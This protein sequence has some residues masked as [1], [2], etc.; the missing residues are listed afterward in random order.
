MSARSE[1]AAREINKINLFFGLMPKLGLR[2]AKTRPFEGMT[3][4]VNA[5]LTTLTATLIRELAL[6]GG[7]WVVSASGSATTDRAVVDLLREQGIPVFSGGGAVDRHMEV[8]KHNPDLIADVGFDLIETLIERRPDLTDKVRGA[9]ELTRSGITKLRGLD[10]VP[11][12]VINIHDGELKPHV[13]NRH[14]VG[15]SLWLAVRD[16]TG[17]H[18]AGRRVLVVGY[19][20]VGEG[21]AAYARA[22][23]AIVQVVDESPVKRLA[24]HY[25][26]FG[27]PDMTEALRCAEIVVTATGVTGALK[28]K[29][30][31]KIERDI[32]LVNAGHGGD[33]IDIAGLKE[34][35]SEAVEVGKNCTRYRLGKGRWISVLG[36]GYPLNIVTNSGSPEPVLLH[37]ALLGLTLEWLAKNSI[38]NGEMQV[39]K[40]VEEEVAKLALEVLT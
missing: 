16:E 3:I 2:W 35:A 17:L 14:G 4:A 10:S 40:S 28:V 36:D 19:G 11:I 39:P 32:V 29:H 38:E 33:E 23:G 27:V 30:L 6:G 18:L 13:E 37:F 1:K 31:K 20:T 22:G 34:S 9:V 8:L 21:I 12:G 7:S 5:H 24:A 25:D 26:G 15:E